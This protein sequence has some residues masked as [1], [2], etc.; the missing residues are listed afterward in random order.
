MEVYDARRNVVNNNAVLDYPKQDLCVQG[1]LSINIITT[2]G[3]F[4]SVSRI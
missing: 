2:A 4:L 1:K 3:L